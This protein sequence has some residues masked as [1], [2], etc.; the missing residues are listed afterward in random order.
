[1]SETQEEPTQQAAAAE[2]SALDQELAETKA[3]ASLLDDIVA[4]YADPIDDHGGAIGRCLRTAKGA[5][6]LNNGITDEMMLDVLMLKNSGLGFRT[7]EATRDGG[8]YPEAVVRSIFI[9][10]CMRGLQVVGN[11]FNIIAGRLYITKEGFSRMLREYEGLTELVIT[12]GLPD[13]RDKRATVHVEASWKLN[14][15]PQAIARDIPVRVNKGMGDDAVLGKADRK[16]KAAIFGQITGSEQPE[17]EV[18]PGEAASKRHGLSG[19][20]EAASEEATHKKDAATVRT[21]PEPRSES[22]PLSKADDSHH[23]DPD[24]E[25]GDVLDLRLDG[26]YRQ[27]YEDAT[28]IESASDRLV[29]IDALDAEATE[30]PLMAARPYQ[31]AILG[32]GGFSAKARLR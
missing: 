31:Q 15:L 28:L 12:P 23:A 3:Q 10:A 6:A 29:V 16:I 13:I 21:P 19:A 1:M 2:P 5:L 11:E 9:E 17:G 4:A 32:K 14:G 20:I 26:Y 22:L 30:D 18:D 8:A 25:Q 7:D 27:K 24:A